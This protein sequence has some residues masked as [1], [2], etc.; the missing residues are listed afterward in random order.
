MQEMIIDPVI[1]G[2]QHHEMFL[3]LN[4]LLNQ[5]NEEEDEHENNVALVPIQEDFANSLNDPLAV[6]VNIPIL[7]GPT[8]NF[9]P[10]E[11]QEDDLMDDA[12]IQQIVAE[13]A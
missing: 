11:I 12:E 10:L 1:Q 2:P 7:D 6:E 9:M 4:D 8:E 13:A 3:E 5:V